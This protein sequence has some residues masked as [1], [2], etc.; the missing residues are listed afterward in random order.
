MKAR[1]QNL[2]TR[3]SL[4]L[5]V[6]IWVVVVCLSL[7]GTEAFSIWHAR[8]L[9]LEHGLENTRNLTRAIA[10][11][12]DDVMLLTDSVTASLADRIEANGTAPAGLDRLRSFV[13]AQIALLP[14]LKALG[15]LDDQGWALVTSLPVPVSENYADRDYFQF[16]QAHADRGLRIG[17]P[18]R[19]KTKGEWIIPVT[20]RIDRADGSFAG[21]VLATIDMAYFQSFYDTFSIGGHGS[22][23]L[24]SGD[25]RLLARRPFDAANIGRSLLEG[26]IF[27][28]FLPRQAAGSAEMR[29]STDGVIRLNSYRRTDAYPLVVAV[30]LDKDEVLAEWRAATSRHALAVGLLVL[31]LAVLGFRLSRQIALRAVMQRAAEAATASASAATAALLE[32]RVRLQA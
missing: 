28:D 15:V 21:V 11:H 27:H 10:Q 16:H 32:S 2:A 22:I 13:A 30:A 3:L 19:S 12:A 23:L 5:G 24:A 29:S 1:L 17:S 4:H 25:G 7:V 9:A 20:R 31:G 14:P 8:S 26:K 18:I 6:A